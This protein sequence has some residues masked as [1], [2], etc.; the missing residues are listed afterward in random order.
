MCARLRRSIARPIATVSEAIL[1]F[2]H[3]ARARIVSSDLKSCTAHSMSA[4]KSGD[5]LVEVG[6]ITEAL[7]QL[8][9]KS[10]ESGS[11]DD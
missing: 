6:Q 9:S 10:A 1:A 5:R 8:S 3:I 11:T 4:S 2:F 7:Q